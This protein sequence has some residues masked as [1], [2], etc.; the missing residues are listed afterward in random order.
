M[1]KETITLIIWLSF[2]VIAIIVASV[3]YW[4]N[5]PIKKL[6]EKRACTHDYQQVKQ[7]EN[8]FEDGISGYIFIYKCTKCGKFKKVK[9]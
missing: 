7:I 3:F 5:E 1:D 2:I 8:T 6:I 9:T 4:F